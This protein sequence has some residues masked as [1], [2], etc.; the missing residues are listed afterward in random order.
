[1]NENGIH[2][3]HSVWEVDCFDFTS[4]HG[5]KFDPV[6]ARAVARRKEY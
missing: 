4:G 2:S 5:T 3:N 1:M 6:Q